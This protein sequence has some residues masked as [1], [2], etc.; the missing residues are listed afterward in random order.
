MPMRITID[1]T[2]E[3]LQHFKDVMQKARDAAV[4]TDARKIT[5]A[6]GALLGEVEGRDV[7]HFVADRLSRLQVLI[8]MLHDAGWA[9]PDAERERVLSALVYFSDPE[10]MIPDSI[11]G[12]GFIDDAIMVELVT[13]E[14]KHEIE[15]YD[16]FRRYRDVESRRRGV[17]SGELDRAQWLQEK[18]NQLQARMKRRRAKPR[19]AR[20]SGRGPFSLF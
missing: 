20:S 10:D 1:L 12:L 14:L 16:D 2:D 18:R 9:L 11:P 7:P 19:T 4:E 17:N 5:E 3:D 6:A 13:R 15:A 8:D